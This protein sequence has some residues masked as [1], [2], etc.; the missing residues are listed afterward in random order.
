[1]YVE[2]ETMRSGGETMKLLT[3]EILRQLPKIGANENKTAN[4]T[5]VSLKLFDPCGRL[6]YYVTEF[7]GDDMLYGYMVSPL[8]SDCDEFG[9]ASLLELSGVRNRLGLGIERDLHW[10]PNTTLAEAVPKLAEKDSDE[11]AIVH[12]AESAFE[13]A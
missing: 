6:T 12:A 7:D 4:E 2:C 3:K 13:R 8:G 11:E 1:L 5:K 10:N 9:Y